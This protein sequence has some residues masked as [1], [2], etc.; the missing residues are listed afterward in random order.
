[1]IALIFCFAGMLAF[2]AHAIK[3]LTMLAIEISAAVET[4]IYNTLVFG[5][6]LRL[7]LRRSIID[8]H[9]R[10]GVPADVEYRMNSICKDIALRSRI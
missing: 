1:M 2:G 7:L 10:E 6:R 4:H 8:N 9:S 5:L 3:L